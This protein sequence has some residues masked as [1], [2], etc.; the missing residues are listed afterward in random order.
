MSE[1]KQEF[2][3]IMQIEKIKSNKSKETR[4]M[5]GA[6][7]LEELAAMRARDNDFNIGQYD[8]VTIIRYDDNY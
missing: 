4:K 5:F 7:S 2:A 8:Q 3:K 1:L 6:D